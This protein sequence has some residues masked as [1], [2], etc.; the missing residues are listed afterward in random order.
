MK[1]TIIGVTALVAVLV[2]AAMVPAATSAEQITT[3]GVVDINRVYNSFYRDSQGVRELERLRS[4]Y[5]DEINQQLQELQ[6]LRDRRLQAQD[7]GNDRRVED[8]DQQI[9]D[10]EQFLEDLPRRRRQQ[11]QQRQ[12]SLLSYDFFRQMQEA[13][14][15]VAE[16]EGFTVVLRSDA[17]GLQWWSNQVDI[18]DAVVQRLIQVSDR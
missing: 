9:A 11:L 6:S 18:S 13:I 8:L 3:V 2:S 1:R 4:E 16:Q 17:S 5:Q 14:Q 7:Q 12:Q 15:F 10:M